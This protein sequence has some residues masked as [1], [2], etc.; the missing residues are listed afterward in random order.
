MKTTIN[1]LGTIELSGTVVVSDPCYD[2]DVWCMELGVKVKPG[3]YRVFASRQDEGRFG[4]RI[5]CIMAVHEDYEVAEIKKWEDCSDGIGVDSGQCGIFDDTIYPQGKN[6][7]DFEPFYDECCGLTLSEESVGILQ[8]SKGVVS[9]S[10]YGDG[11]YT[12]CSAF[13]DGYII[14]LLLDY[15]LGKMNQVM[16]AL[17]SRQKE[18][19]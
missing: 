7:P 18:A 9:S 12:L 11:S 17:V 6:H 10:G 16:Q 1:E 15:D 3:T 8:N 2:R 13:Q 14:G 19:K 4:I 5:A